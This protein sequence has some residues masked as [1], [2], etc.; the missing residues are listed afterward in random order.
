MFQ[1]KRLS[2]FSAVIGIV[3][4]S[5]CASVTISAVG[6]TD[7]KSSSEVATS[8][9]VGV[10]AV[11]NRSAARTGVTM[12]TDDPAP[13]PTTAPPPPPSAGALETEILQLVN[14]ERTAR[15]LQPLS[16]DQRLSAAATAHSAHQAEIGTIF[17]VAPDGTTPGERITAAGYVFSAW[18]ENVAAGHTSPEAVVA[19][20]MASPGHCRNLLNPA[21]VHLG[22]GFVE[23]TTSFRTW[24]TQ[25]FARPMG[26]PSP[27]GTFDPAWC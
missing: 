12:V 19:G 15:G 17:H 18:A 27:A 5:L 24:W 10:S 22:V 3:G 20:W 9:S 11:A 8:A 26:T 1:A 21:Y 2:R 14:A 25:K 7:S 23:T 13:P 4:V 16:L 6:D